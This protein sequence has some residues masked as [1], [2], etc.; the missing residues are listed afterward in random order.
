[1]LDPYKIRK[2]FPMYRNNKKMQGHDLVFLDNAST[3]FK[4]DC[5]IEAV[6]N[7]LMNETANSHR[8]DYDLCINVNTRR[9][10]SRK[11]VAKFNNAKENEVV[12]TNENSM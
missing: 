5:V 4:P 12:I 6:N 1:M 11:R 7:Y 10:E 2:D 3:T 8:G 9:E